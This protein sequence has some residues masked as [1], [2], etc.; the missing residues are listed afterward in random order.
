LDES[1]SDGEHRGRATRAQFLYKQW[2][3]VWAVSRQKG[4]VDIPLM[5]VEEILLLA[6]S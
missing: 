6:S 4:S 1:P 5:T 2:F 3:S